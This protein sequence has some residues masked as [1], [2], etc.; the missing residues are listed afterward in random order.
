MTRNAF[1]T[2]KCDLSFCVCFILV[3]KFVILAA[4]M[5][6]PDTA[7]RGEVA[8]SQMSKVKVDI[9]NLTPTIRTS[10]W[11]CKP[12]HLINVTD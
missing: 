6:H 2:Y 3:K 7:S 1:D 8:S 5:K 11:I 10:S 9:G 12:S 4:T